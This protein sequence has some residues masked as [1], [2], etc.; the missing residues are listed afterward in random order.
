M[1]KLFVMAITAVAGLIAGTASMGCVLAF[2]D[3]P[4]MP[5]NMIER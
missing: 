3:E 1:K 2:F 5:R 4:T